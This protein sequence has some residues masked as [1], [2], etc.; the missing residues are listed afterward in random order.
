[1]MSRHGQAV[2]PLASGARRLVS[3][4]GSVSVRVRVLGFHKV[5]SEEKTEYIDFSIRFSIVVYICAALD[6]SSPGSL[7][8][9]YC[10]VLYCT[11]VECVMRNAM[12]CDD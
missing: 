3:T 5:I 10:T 7:L 11:V 8:A 6:R 2:V 1:M 4:Y 9:Q 12:T